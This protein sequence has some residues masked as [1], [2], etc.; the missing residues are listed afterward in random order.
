MLVPVLKRPAASRTVA[1]TVYRVPTLRGQR[2]RQAVAAGLS[3]PGTGSPF[4]FTETCTIV[5][6]LTLIPIP[7][8]GLTLSG[9]VGG[10]D[11]E[12]GGGQRRRRR[13]RRW[14]PA[15]PARR[16]DEAQA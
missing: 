12:L 9:A 11:R 4:V 15:A 7:F 1:L 3:V 14:L 5:P 6:S 13:S 8:W 2:L 10:R 16:G